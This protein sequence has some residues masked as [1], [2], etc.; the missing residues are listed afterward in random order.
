MRRLTPVF[1]IS[2]GLAILTCSILV[3]VDL[4]GVL[5][6]RLDEQLE[7]R[8]KIVETLAMQ[9]IPAVES[10]DFASVRNVLF[11]AVRRNDDLQSAGLRGPRGQLMISTGKHRQLWNPGSGA[12][13]SATHVRIPIYRNGTRW[14]TLEVRFR[15][16]ADA[17]PSGLL[18]SLWDRTL[19]RLLLLV[20]GLGFLGF[21]IYMRRTLRHL[22]PSAVIPARVQA[23]FDV[24]AEGVLLLDQNERIVLANSTFADRIDRPAETLIGVKAS[25]LGWLVPKSLEPAR[26]LPWQRALEDSE[27]HTGTPLSIRVGPDNIETFL[28]NGAPVTE[29][30]GKARGA[31]A[32]FDNVTELERKTEELEQALA[33]LEK[34]RD[35]TR[36][37]ND[38][39]Q[40]MATCDPLTGAV[41]RRAFMQKAELEFETAVRDGREL[42]CVM[43]DIDH[44]KRVNDEHGHSTGDE[45]IRR[46]AQELVSA[47]HDRELVCRYGGE[48]FCMLLAE[49]DAEGGVALASRLCRSIAA[50]GFAPVPLSASFG[51]SSLAS[52][53]SRFQDLLDQADQALYASKKNGRNQVTRWEDISG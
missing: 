5:P 7:S 10:D 16:T 15:G 38:E 39:L 53:A 29:E 24:M 8:I 14:A 34:S 51:V 9:T 31:I 46:L 42:C 26:D 6:E 20:G 3:L 49:T 43:V 4:L 27:R 40:V 32:T 48:E 2:L 44:F 50:E 12:L 28:V 35:E 11:V 13:S 23:A 18:K 33:L 47:W 19:I 41:N 36:L 1:R 45:V 21:W 52:G 37:R 25:D 30:S 17:G 22:D